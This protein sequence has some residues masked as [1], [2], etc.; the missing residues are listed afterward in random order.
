MQP[1]KLQP[2]ILAF[3]FL[4]ASIP[5]A[6][7]P[8]VF[9]STILGDANIEPVTSTFNAQYVEALTK[10]TVTQAIVIHSVSMYL[11]YT[12]SDG[13]QCLKFAIYGDDG[14][15][16]GQSSPLNQPLISATQ[17]GYCFVTG[18]F[19]PAWETWTL[20]PSDYLTIPSSGVYWLAV[21][22]KESYGTIYHFTYTGLYPGQYLYNYGYF[23]YGFP[24]SYALGIP[25][26]VF[27]AVP[28]NECLILPYNSGNVGE[29]NAPYSFYVSTG[30]I[31]VPEFPSASAIV[32]LSCLILV[33]ATILKRS[34][35]QNLR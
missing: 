4:T 10:I 12:G 1:S 26:T 29:Y 21:L 15:S 33:L 19:G 2:V 6:T 14:G 30:P 7:P 9:A 8:S 32:L 11:Q 23:M 35:W 24:A 5:L 13:S 25:S 17:N 34:R 28:C 27:G 16:Y 3:L 22:P 20:Q 18:N 31:T